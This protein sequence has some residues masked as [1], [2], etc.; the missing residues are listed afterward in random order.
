MSLML[1]LAA[2]WSLSLQGA[3]ALATVTIDSVHRMDCKN[4]QQ[5]MKGLLEHDSMRRKKRLSPCNS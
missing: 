3:L 5:L 4:D 1:L 2:M